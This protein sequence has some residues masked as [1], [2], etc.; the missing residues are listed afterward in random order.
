MIIN[1]YFILIFLFALLLNFLIRLVIYFNTGLF[2]FS[3]YTMYLKGIDRIDS[4]KIVALGNGNFFMTIS[5]IGYYAKY[6]IGSINWFF[7]FNC[8]LGSLTSLFTYILL[9]KITAS[10]KAGIIAVILQTIYTEFMV[11]SSVFYS[12]VL[13]VFLLSLLLILLYNYYTYIN[14]YYVVLFGLSACVILMIT[15]LFKPALIFLPVFLFLT[16]ILLYKKKKFIKRTI[17]LSFTFIAGIILIY[18]SVLLKQDKNVM[19]NDFLFFGHTDYGGDGGEGA[20]IYS[21]N[22]VRYESA[23]VQ[24]CAE[25]NI[26]KPDRRQLNEFQ[27]QEIIKFITKHPVQWVKLQSTKFFRTFGVVPE[28]SSFKILYTGL[29]KDKLWLTAF[30]V[31][32]PIP[33]IIILF[34]QL[35]NLSTL[36]HL[37]KCSSF[38]YIYLMLF[39]YYIIATIFFGHYQE[40]YRLPVMVCFIIPFAAIF[41]SNFNIKDYLSKP[42]IYIRSAITVLF[43]VI[44]IFQAKAA[45]LNTDRLDK[46]IETINNSLMVE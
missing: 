41:I 34:I 6:I 46:A 37:L 28:G 36:Q 18:S 45:I 19:A 27:R 14:T 2:Y 35:F 12:P 31:V 26:E 17:I 13:M 23:L 44:W 3:D 33:L 10:V 24:Y 16:A 29:L 8:L 21:E 25:N 20:F 38:M 22:R 42:G 11:F 43:L 15:L 39:I 4:G 5:Y 1:R 7:I 40:R 32:L 9:F 30:L